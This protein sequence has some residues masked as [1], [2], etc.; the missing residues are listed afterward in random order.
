MARVQYLMAELLY[1]EHT[2]GATATSWT[3]LTQKWDA[4]RALGRPAAHATEA[5]AEEVQEHVRERGEGIRLHRE[6]QLREQAR[7]LYLQVLL[8]LAA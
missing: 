8:V 1:R 6:E 2:P 5:R 3:E 7:E 4:D